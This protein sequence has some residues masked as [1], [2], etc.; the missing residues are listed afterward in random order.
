MCAMQWESIQIFIQFH[1]EIWYLFSLYNIKNSSWAVRVL[2]SQDRINKMLRLF[3]LRILCKLTGKPFL[4]LVAKRVFSPQFK[5]YF[6]SPCLTNFL[7]RGAQAMLSLI[8]LHTSLFGLQMRHF[9]ILIQLLIVLWRNL[10]LV[11]P[12]VIRKKSSQI[13]SII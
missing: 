7:I 12:F 8:S 11:G 1:L 6:Y 10:Y 9:W 3:Q 5:K 2:L 13:C 4:K